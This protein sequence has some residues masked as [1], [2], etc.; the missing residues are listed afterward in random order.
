[1][2]SREYSVTPGATSTGFP[3]T[4]ELMLGEGPCA[5]CTCSGRRTS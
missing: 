2:R 4:R 3:D 5:L 1:M